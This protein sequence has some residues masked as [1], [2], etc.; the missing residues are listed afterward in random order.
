MIFKMSRTLSNFTQDM[1]KQGK[2][3]LSWEK[4]KNRLNAKKTQMLEL[5]HKYFE[6]VIT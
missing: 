5:S 4:T 2:P 6:V 1:K 3:Q